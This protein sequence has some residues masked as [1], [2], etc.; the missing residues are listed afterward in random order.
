MTWR[1]FERWTWI[2]EDKPF[3]E[4]A[5]DHRVADTMIFHSN[6]NSEKKDRKELT[7]IGKRNVVNGRRRVNGVVARNA[8]EAG[9]MLRSL[10]KAFE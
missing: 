1:E 8:E 10:V 4:L 3:G 9:Q 6:L 2:Y 7:F 5:Q